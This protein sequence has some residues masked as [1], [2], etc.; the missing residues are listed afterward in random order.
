MIRV[1]AYTIG[2]ALLLFLQEYIFNAINVFGLVGI[3]AYIMIIIMLP[4]SVPRAW[5]LIVGF[6]IGYL[7]DTMSGSAGLNAICCVWLAFAR[8]YAAEATL[9]RDMVLAGVIPSVYRVGATRFMTYV[10]LMCLL[11]AA[12]YFTLEM[13]DLNGFG[14]VALRILGST[15]TTSILIF[16]FHLPFSRNG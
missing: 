1:L 10:A 13:M 6:L 7:V 9:G 8:P 15:I 12:P 16:I 5:L 4:L 3:F 14:F 11:F 2:F